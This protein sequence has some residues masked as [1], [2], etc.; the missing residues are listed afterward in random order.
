MKNFERRVSEVH[1]LNTQ[2]LGH[3]LYGLVRFLRPDTIVETG[4]Y[5]GHSTCWLAKGIKDND[6][7]KL[8][9]IDNFTLGTSAGIL[10]NS[11]S[12]C[13]VADNI[14]II[15]GDSMS[16]RWP[17]AIDM[18]FLDGNHSLEYVQF[19]FNKCVEAGARCI[20][21]HDT[22]DWWGPREFVAPLIYRYIEYPEFGGMRVY[23][24]NYGIDDVPVNNSRESNP[25]GTV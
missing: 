3:L 19:E 23:M 8:V 6:K 15:D 5:V 21:L 14:I 4:S 7:G 11:L 25:K 18:A 12:Y 10:H 24:L 20:V 22:T 17:D 2:R 16:C 1:G 9:A 13:K